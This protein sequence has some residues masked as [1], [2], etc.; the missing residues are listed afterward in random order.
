[1]ADAFTNSI[2]LE[3]VISDNNETNLNNNEIKSLS[4]IYP[5]LS[6]SQVSTS[7]H[8]IK[9]TITV[10]ADIVKKIYDQTVKLFTYGS[11]DGFSNNLIPAEYIK[12]HYKTEIAKKVKNFLFRHAIIDYLLNK[13]AEYKI[14]YANYPRLTS[15]EEDS[16]GG[17]NYYFDLSIADP[18]E[19]KEWKHFAFKSPKR[20]K[21]K[22]LDKQVIHFLENEI[23]SAKK[24]HNSIIEDNDWVLFEALALDHENNPIFDKLSLFWLKVKTKEIPSQFSHLFLEK[25]INESFTTTSFDVDGSIGDDHNPRQFNFLITIKACTKGNFLSLE[26]F[27][28]MFKL[29]NKIDVHNKLMEVFSYRNDISQ[30]KTIIEEIF[31]LFLAKHRFEVPKH[32]ILRRQEDILLVLMKQTDYQVYKSQ[33]DF[34]QQVELLAEKQLKEEI[35]I[36]QIA[37]QENIKCD[38]KDIQHYLHLF[39]NKRLREFIYFKPL[40]EQIDEANRPI[41]SGILEQTALREKTLN[42]IIVTLTR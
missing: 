27:R 4:L 32:L 26:N 10:H 16:T 19:L 23:A 12:E 22:D 38:L 2:L 28:G 30:R 36:D 5:Y 42:Y 17:L 3:A 29:K 20:K 35:I 15:I 9:I 24:Q 14:P 33:K 11:L 7:S 18:I 37:T 31:H 6:F 34:L 41:S 8:L 13:S 39:N 40:L 25:S 21:Y 1:M